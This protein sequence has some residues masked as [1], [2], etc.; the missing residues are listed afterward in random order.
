MR[1]KDVKR[2]S[3]GYYFKKEIV[4]KDLVKEYGI[5]K[6]WLLLFFLRERF[7]Y[8][9]LLEIEIL[10]KLREEEVNRIKFLL[11]C[12]SIG[13]RFVFKEEEG[14]ILL[15]REEKSKERCRWLFCRFDGKKSESRFGVVKFWLVESIWNSSRK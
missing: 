9:K 11:W 12:F 7:Y 2:V 3:V 1:G 13:E 5:K 4:G 14:Y 8:V 15:K 6:F 10:K